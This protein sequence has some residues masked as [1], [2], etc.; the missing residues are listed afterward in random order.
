MK[1]FLTGCCLALLLA[2]GTIWAYST[3]S[4]SSATRFS[5]EQV[6]HV[7][8]SANPRLHQGPP[9]IETD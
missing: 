1:G 4:F 6:V 8:Q 9:P 2:G 5:D 7:D 3:F